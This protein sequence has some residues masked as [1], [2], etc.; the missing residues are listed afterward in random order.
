MKKITLKITKKEEK[1][2]I[3]KALGLGVRL[4]NAQNGFVRQ[5]SVKKSKKIY[6]RKKKVKYE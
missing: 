5:T 6:N 3:I 2:L 1:I 4:A